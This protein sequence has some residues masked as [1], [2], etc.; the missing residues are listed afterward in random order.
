[1]KLSLEHVVIV[2]LNKVRWWRVF[3]VNTEMRNLFAFHVRG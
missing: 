2:A 1:M 3:V